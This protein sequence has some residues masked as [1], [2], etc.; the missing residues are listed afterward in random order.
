MNNL[1]SVLEISNFQNSYE[2]EYA[3]AVYLAIASQADNA[4]DK[5]AMHFI[6]DGA[7]YQS[8]ISWTYRQLLDDIHRTAN[9]FAGL[10]IKANEAGI[11]NPINPY[12]EVLQLAEIMNACESRILVTRG[13]QSD[14]ASWKKSQLLIKHVASLEY[15]I[16]VDSDD[17]E[18]VIDN[19]YLIDTAP[20][21]LN[22]HVEKAKCSKAKLEFEREYSKGSI[23]AYFHTGGTTGSPK[24]APHTHGNQ[25]ANTSIMDKLLFLEEGSKFFCGL[26]WFHAN[27][28]IVTGIC[29]FTNGH[30]LILGTAAGYKGN[31]ILENFWKIIEHY[32]INYFSAVPTILQYLLT[33]PVDGC[34]LSSMRNAIC[35]AAPLSVKLFKDFED[36]TQINI[37]EGYGFTEGTAMST[38]NPVNGERKI[39]SIGLNIPYHD[40]KI[41]ILNENKS[42]KRFAQIDESGMII[43]RGPS[44]F[45]G[46][47]DQGHNKNI[48]LEH[49]NEKWFITGDLGKVDGD[50]F[51]WITGR[52]K[53]LIIRGGHNIDPKS[54]EEPLSK[55]HAVAAVAAIGRPDLKVGELPV[56]FVQLK[57]GSNVSAEELM[58]YAAKNI[59]E[60][61]AV[62][63]K[64][65]IKAA[66][67]LTAVG[68]IFKPVLRYEE[69][70]HVFQEELSSINGIGSFEVFVDNDDKKFFMELH[71]NFVLGK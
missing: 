51:F 18:L 5:V 26:P 48:W 38:L 25:L 57:K 34:N 13:P 36:N 62:P 11:V 21:I 65:Y 70:K 19:K 61:A 28:V 29:L 2:L 31:G 64:I 54:I 53:D 37:L 44:I 8:S 47:K 27:G 55:H 12:L 9:M 20:R 50:G 17:T 71:N 30:T 52:K 7:K 4:P 58:D 40:L 33:V 14:Q 49:E 45:P 42:F 16:I 6:E 35:G 1:S 68:K 60:K 10:G 46:Y 66:L 67:P 59:L 22:F 3:E 43:A 63:K 24:I 39:G 56:A 41:A 23:A 69:I 15:I 32:K